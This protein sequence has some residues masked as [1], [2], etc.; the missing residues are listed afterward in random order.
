MIQKYITYLCSRINE[1][2]D[3]FLK[4]KWVL[5]ETNLKNE[6]NQVVQMYEISSTFKV[7]F[8]D[9]LDGSD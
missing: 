3:K 8:V 2:S 5:T 9:F 6:Y 7:I 1:I 4:D